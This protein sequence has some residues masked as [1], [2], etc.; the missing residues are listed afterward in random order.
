MKRSP[1][2]LPNHAVDLEVRGNMLIVLDGIDGAG[3]TTQTATLVKRL[4][5]EGRTVATL[6]FPQYNRTFFGAIVRRFLNGEF[7]AIGEINPH[8]AAL[9]YALDRFEMKEKLARW[10]RQK[11]II[12]LNRY[13]TSNLIHQGSKLPGNKRAAFTA[14]IE[15]MEY[16]VLA[17]PRPNLVVYL[18]LP[19]PLAYALIKKRG[20]RKDIHERNRKHLITAA[21]YGLELA[22]KK[23]WHIIKCNSGNNIR[24]KEEIAED[25]WNIVNAKFQFKIQNF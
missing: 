15:E 23:G 21:R 4:K 9:L 25:I 17:L 3:K 20:K 13:T 10:L 22:R 5:K 1:K 16:E 14:W 24:T 11:K 19:Y 12:V 18:S 7:G 2:S 6:D 8:L